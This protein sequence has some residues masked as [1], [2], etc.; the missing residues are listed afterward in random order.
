[1]ARK[2]KVVLPKG[3]GPKILVYDIE[4]AGVNAFN[5]DLGY[6]IAFG[7]KWLG[8]KET[9][10]LS[11]SDYP[12]FKKDPHNDHDLLRDASEV[13]QHA[14]ALIAHYGDKFDRPFIHT[15]LTFHDLPN[16]PP[17]KQLDTCK[18][19][20]KVYKFSSNRLANLAKFFN[21]ANRKTDK[22]DGWSKWWMEIL[23]GSDKYQKQMVDYCKQDVRTLEEIA[24]KMR[25][26]WPPGFVNFS[27]HGEGIHCCTRCGSKDLTKD[28]HRYRSGKK[29]QRY[30][31]KA[32]GSWSWGNSVR[33]VG[34]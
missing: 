30:C 25:N 12:R 8:E 21:C 13:F 9:H 32:C 3:D 20:W 28:G 7:Y 26:F 16:I 29:T 11:I 5:A 4:S 10:C 24:L 2:S 27:S 18:V 33:L 34:L 23:K 1:M 15:R 14:D 22:G 19:A 17:I 31:C 6:V